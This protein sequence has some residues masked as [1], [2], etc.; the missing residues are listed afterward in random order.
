MDRRGFVEANV[1][2]IREATRGWDAGR[3]EQSR[4][5]FTAHAIP[6]AIAKTGPYVRQV[7]ETAA[8]VACCLKKDFSVAFQSGPAK[9]NIPWTGPDIRDV[10]ER[11]GRPGLD[12]LV[13]PIGFL[14]DNVEVLYDLDVEAMQAAESR[15]ARLARAGTVGSHPAFIGMLADRIAALA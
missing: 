11:G 1:A 12:F 14:C 13:S 4:L 2:R 7:E 5:V 10:I 9:P 6:E 15:G 8:A 3:L